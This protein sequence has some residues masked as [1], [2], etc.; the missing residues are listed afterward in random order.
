MAA[1]RRQEQIPSYCARSRLPARGSP[2][3]RMERKR[4][5]P[6]CVGADTLIGNICGPARV[7]D[8]RHWEDADERQW[9]VRMTKEAV[10][11]S[12][13]KVTAG[14]AVEADSAHARATFQRARAARRGAPR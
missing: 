3:R 2:A 14:R 4:R 13:T 11:H 6:C 9:V 12:S 1:R 10:M 7:V 8:A 5:S